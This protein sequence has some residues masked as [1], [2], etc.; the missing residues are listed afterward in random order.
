MSDYDIVW[1]E[2]TGEWDHRF[3]GSDFPVDQNSGHEIPVAKKPV[4]FFK[5]DHLVVVILVA[6]LALIVGLWRGIKSEE[7]I[8][9][10]IGAVVGLV[11]M[12]IADR[13]RNE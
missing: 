2:E 7:A 11:I 12:L 3:S 6:L 8:H 5:Y 13:Y 1:N 9:F 4:P 10:I